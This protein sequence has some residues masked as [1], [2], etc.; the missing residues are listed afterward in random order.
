VLQRVNEDV[1]N[2]LRLA[3][4]DEDRA[5]TVTDSKLKADNSEQ[6]HS[7]A[8]E[9]HPPRAA[10]ALIPKIW[11][12][13]KSRSLLVRSLLVVL[14]YLIAVAG[15]QA[16][17]LI[18]PGVVRYLTFF[19]ALLVAGLLCGL[20]PSLIL[21]AAFVAT[22]MFLYDPSEAVPITIRVAIALLFAVGGAGV[23]IP[24][25]YAARTQRILRAQDHR[26]TLLNSELRHRVKNLFA[27][28]CSICSQSAR[29]TSDLHELISGIIGRIQAIAT[30]Q[31]Y[32]SITSDKGSDL[33]TLTEAIIGPMCPDAARLQIRG[34]SVTLAPSATTSFALILNE[35]ATNAVK[36]GGWQF[37]G[38]GK[39]IVTW[40]LGTTD[41]EFQWREHGVM[42]SSPTRQ[43]FGRTLIARSLTNA[44]VDH[45]FH[46]D[47]VQCNIRLELV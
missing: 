34:P 23:V 45:L 20:V 35:L 17:H 38:D 10:P 9:Q 11:I 2:S 19:P 46:P 29:S 22:G 25:W 7:Q 21:L 44:K 37:S 15:R 36:Y 18:V 4:E 30:A 5:Q 40:R 12:D 6:D 33:R 42:I 47:G 24:A 28:T 14:L 26:L 16:A 31:D 8:R 3:A 39:V 13:E 41:L 32:I 1:A 27:L 43:G